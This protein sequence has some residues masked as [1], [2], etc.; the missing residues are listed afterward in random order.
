MKRKQRK[1]G[2][3]SC[4]ASAP[5]RK[6]SEMIWEFAGDFIRFGDTL[7]DRQNRLN[8]A[9]SAWN[10]ACNPPEARRRMLDQYV[11]SYRTYNPH[12]ASEDLSAIRRD[13]ETLMQ[14]KLRLFPD[15]RSQIV[16]AQITQV[17]GKDRIDVASARCE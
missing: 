13:M 7:E 10:M 14:N 3:S 17:A 9:C 12:T 6:I 11:D 16:S 15:V 8:A 1:K 2:R 4:D 5:R